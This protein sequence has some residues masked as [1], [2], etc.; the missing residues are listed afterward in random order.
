MKFFLIDVCLFCLCLFFIVSHSLFPFP[1]KMFAQPQ[2]CQL[3]NTWKHL[4]VSEN[5]ELELRTSV[6]QADFESVL[7]HLSD[8]YIAYDEHKHEQKSTS[9]CIRRRMDCI[10]TDKYYSSGSHDKKQIRSRTFSNQPNQVIETI[11]KERIA[12]LDILVVQRAY[13]VRLALKRESPVMKKKDEKVGDMVNNK[14]QTQRDVKRTS[15]YT[16]D[17]LRIDLSVIQQ[18]DFLVNNGMTPTK[19]YEIEI[20]C[21]KEASQ[22]ETERIFASLQYWSLYTMDCL[23]KDIKMLFIPVEYK[24][25]TTLQH[26]KNAKAITSFCDYVWLLKNRC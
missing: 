3:I 14:L 15:F 2:C 24:S 13:D 12:F 16:D 22:R 23:K 9:K 8:G 17:D 10:F 26:D 25:F 18:H 7:K 4:L 5:V 20:E 11:E 6:S 19:T 21:L 1:S